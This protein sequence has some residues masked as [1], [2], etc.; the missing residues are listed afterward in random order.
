MGAAGDLGPHQ[1]GLGPEDGGVDLLQPLPAHV[2]VAVA[3]G[4]GKA[5]RVHAVFPH[6][7][8]DLALVQLGHL[9]DLLK[10]RLQRRQGL[11]PEG[12]HLG[13]DAVFLIDFNQIHGISSVV[14]RV[15]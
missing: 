3:G 2:V 10:A 15:S 1:G 8:D 13:G 11:L 9:V 7:K 14:I 6:G 12:V 4:G 5:G